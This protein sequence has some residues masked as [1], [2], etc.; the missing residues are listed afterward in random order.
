M[1]LIIKSS[2]HV[3]VPRDVA[4]KVLTDI[5]RSA[6]CF[7]GAE[8]GE[9]LPDGS[10]TGTFNVKLGPLT[11]RFSGN[12][13]FVETDA[14]AVTAKLSASGTDTKGRGG[15]RAIVDVAM[16]EEGG[17]TEVRIVSDAALSGSVAQYGRGAGMIQALS[18]Q[19]I[20]DFA[21]NLSAQMAAEAGAGAAPS[22]MKQ[23]AQPPSPVR[24]VSLL[25][26]SLRA[27][28]R[29]RFSRPSARP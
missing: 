13:G 14:Q 3:D 26:R 10:Y 12:F 29:D 17:R 11:F 23:P 16:F 1:T 20:D 18:Q 25:W 22:A 5:E 7:P 4:W 9:R 15:A 24:G 19:L 21:R 2:F 6:P 8:L 27:W 28:I